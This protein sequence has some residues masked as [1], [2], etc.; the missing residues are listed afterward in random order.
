MIRGS[1][2]SF[3]EYSDRDL[4]PVVRVTVSIE[5]LKEPAGGIDFVIDTGAQFTN[6]QPNDAYLWAEIPDDQLS[7]PAMWPRTTYGSGIGGLGVFFPMPASYRF[8][9]E[10]GRVETIVGRIYIAQLT[11]DNINMPSLMGWDILR[12]FRIAL[13]YG[14][15]E[16]RLTRQRRSA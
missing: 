15:G 8:R 3:D 1:F 2:V 4:M 12:Q 6:I 14:A 13:D 9:H 10:S 11:R 16:A 7:D 5:R